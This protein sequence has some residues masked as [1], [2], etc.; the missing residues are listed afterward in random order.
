MDSIGDA[1]N[2]GQPIDVEVRQ[3]QLNRWIAAR[4]EFGPVLGWQIELEG[5]SFP[6][7]LLLDE[8]RLRIG[9]TAQTRVTA[10]VLSAA[11]RLEL[12]PGGLLVHLESVRAGTLPIPRH[13]VLRP[14]PELL[15]TDAGELGSLSGNTIRLRNQ[16]TW[17][18][19]KRRFRVARLEVSAGV[20]RLRLE[21]LP[22]TP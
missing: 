6:Q 11:G 21:P 7:V 18:N 15:E 5:V 20:A 16:W 19:G 12:T 14:L 22:G 8:N 9:A 1:L 13:S 2:A 10:V 17:P 3:D 4:D